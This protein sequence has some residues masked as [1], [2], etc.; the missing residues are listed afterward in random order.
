MNEKMIPYVLL[1]LVSVFVAAVSQAMLK[2]AA[3]KKYDSFLKEYLN[4]L[5]IC[6]YI[7]FFGTTLIGVVAYK[8]IPISLGPVLEATSYIY[9]TIFG[10]SMFGEKLNRRKVFALGLI[11]L[12]ILIFA[13]A[14]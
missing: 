4:P 6:A 9:V 3:L 2:K 8:V 12:G 7:L 1:F 14:G 13:L 11:I 10:L 5:V